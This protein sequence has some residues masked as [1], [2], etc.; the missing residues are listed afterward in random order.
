MIVRAG[1]K[2]RGIASRLIGEPYAFLARV[3]AAM[4]RDLRR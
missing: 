3:D 1:A 2:S 4:R